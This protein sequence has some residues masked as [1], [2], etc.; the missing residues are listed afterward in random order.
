MPK[1]MS[2]QGLNRVLYKTNDHIRGQNYV[3]NVIQRWDELLAYSTSDNFAI[4][5]ISLGLSM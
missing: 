5:R 1:R 4:G 3:V 2:A